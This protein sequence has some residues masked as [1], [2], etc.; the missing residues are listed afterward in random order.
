MPNQGV[1]LDAVTHGAF[2]SPK[3]RSSG[4]MTMHPEKFIGIISSSFSLKLHITYKPLYTV[5]YILC[6]L[7]K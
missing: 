5:Y 3:H 7:L 2:L 6:I 1:C 4:K